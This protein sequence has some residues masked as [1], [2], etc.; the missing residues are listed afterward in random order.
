M[1]VP[2]HAFVFLLGPLDLLLRRFCFDL[3][4]RDVDPQ[5]AIQIQIGVGD[6]D[7]GEKG[8]HIAAPIKKEQ[9]IMGQKQES[10]GYIMAEAVFAGEEVKEFSLDE[11]AAILA[12]LCAII[13]HLSED[14]LKDHRSRYGGDWNGQNEKRDDHLPRNNHVGVARNCGTGMVNVEVAE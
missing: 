7:Q 8:D 10:G 13:S 9:V 3:L 11:L 1:A 14:F 6:E 2:S 4:S 12:S 5:T